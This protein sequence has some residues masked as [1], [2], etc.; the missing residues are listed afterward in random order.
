MLCLYARSSSLNQY[1][2][3]QMRY[4]FEYLLGQKTP[5]GKSACLGTIFHKVFEVRALAKKALQDGYTYIDDEIFGNLTI[6]ECRDY[7]KITE[8]SYSHYS[9]IE[10]HLKFSEADKK[11][12]LSW[13]EKTLDKYSEYDPFNM[14]IVAAELFFDIEINKEWAKYDTVV[15]GEKISGNMRIKGTM[16][17]IVKHSDTVYE[18]IDYKTGKYREDFATKEEKDLEYLKN[19]TQLLLYLIA[20]K[21][22]Y[23][24]VDF[25]LSL[26][27]INKG[28]MFTIAADDD[29][30]NRAWGMLEKSYKEIS[31]NYNPTQLDKTHKDYRCKFLCPFSKPCADDPSIS[32][33]NR[34]K[35]NISRMGFTKTFSE[36]VDIKSIGNY[37]SGGG[38]QAATL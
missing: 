13:C 32:I 25:M 20:L 19:D 38:R 28:G 9:E 1:K 35:E 33:C 22:I 15:N 36:S 8:L 5:T 24:N 4:Y 12:V 11:T 27:Y 18:L 34:E 37:G 14:N 10:K 31:K 26:F 6:D 3:C 17:T 2:T 7:N 23:P 16:D 21:T 30:L 29:M